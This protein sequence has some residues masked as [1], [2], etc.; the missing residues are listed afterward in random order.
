MPSATDSLIGL[1]TQV[2]GISGRRAEDG[3]VAQQ[4]QELAIKNEANR[5][6][7]NA[8]KDSEVLGEIQHLGYMKVDPETG[9]PTVDAARL[10]KENKQLFRDFMG[11]DV[12]RL[13]STMGPN[14]PEPLTLED[15]E[16][17]PGGLIPSQNPVDETTGST[18]AAPAENSVGTQVPERFMVKVR[19]KDGRVVPATQNASADPNDSLITL[20]PEK[21]Q[22]IADG[23]LGR[24]KARGGL[25]NI[26]T[27]EALGLDWIKLHQD[28]MKAALLDKAD[29]LTG[30]DPV[31]GR[32]LLGMLDDLHG[33][34]LNAAA[35]DA[36]VDIK[37]L[38]ADSAAK[39]AAAQEKARKEMEGKYKVDPDKQFAY[40][41]LKEL[42]TGQYERAT[43]ALADYDAAQPKVQGMT[44]P[45]N[46]RFAMNP[47]VDAP[48]NPKDP[49]GRTDKNKNKTPAQGPDIGKM[50]TTQNGRFAMNPTI[51][52]E[53]VDINKGAKG[54]EIGKMTAPQDG[55]FAMNPDINGGKPDTARQTL[56]KAQQDAQK[57]LSGLKEPEL[58]KLD[59]G[60]PPPKFELTEDNIRDA[61]RGKI[62]EQPSPE[63]V[64]TL[65]QYAKSKGVQSAQDIAKLPRNDG[66]ALS[67][68][69]A[70]N[71]RGTTMDQKLG[72]FNQL[73]NFARTGDT[74]KS[75]IDAAETI[76]NARA[77]VSNAETNRMEAL[78]TAQWRDTQGQIDWAKLGIEQGRLD[79]DMNNDVWKKLGD[80]DAANNKIRG[81]V[82]EIY[83]GTLADDNKIQAPTKEAMAAWKNLRSDMTQ[84]PKGSPQQIAAQQSYLE[85]FF[86]MAAAQSV[87]P[88]KGAW[89]DFTK[90]VATTFLREDGMVNMS[91]LLE[92][93]TIGYGPNGQPDR[94]SF[95][96]HGGSGKENLVVGAEEFK[97]FTGSSDFT[98][99]VNAVH[100][101]Q[102][103]TLLD[104]QGLPASP[105]NL[106]MMVKGIRKSAGMDK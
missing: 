2:S 97:R 73:A 70:M 26:V 75:P 5:D 39:W 103:R 78:N 22:Q 100:T 56:L 55:R 54:P 80:V 25:D 15:L 68:I 104:S 61:I 10:A 40:Q 52:P 87:T 79:R 28:N 85:G 81:Y 105:E 45:P 33:E 20:T 106:E 71:S 49:M 89:W 53:K 31:G 69:I 65:T 63:Q 88:G 86:Q 24:V 57:A 47:A 38:E 12:N 13:L 23:R 27:Q 46:G 7:L 62:G 14:G 77:N 101:F 35:A 17:V 99:F 50:T 72:V 9:R 44:A 74:A 42:Y 95:R 59:S 11:P 48:I 32:E 6:V 82:T 94:I 1:L 43:K 51:A 96:D 18:L 98:F 19:T 8:K 91:P 102:A 92:T 93:A 37:A 60:A 76:A 66:L 84:L 67:W 29:N 90:W 30:G 41:S 3:L 58:I 4:S 64:A 83:N 21:L 16:V 34:D 36:E